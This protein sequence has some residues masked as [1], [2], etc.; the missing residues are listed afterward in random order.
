MET[1]FQTSFIP[2]KPLIPETGF[3]KRESISFFMLIGVV[4]FTL[5]ILS[6]G[7]V[8]VWNKILERKQIEYQNV[9]DANRKAFDAD[10]TEFKRFNSK[11]N[12][13]KELLD[14][15][16]SVSEVFKIVGQLT[17]ESVRFNDFTF[18]LPTNS[19]DGVTVTMKGTG[20]SFSTIAFQSD[21]LAKNKVIK[22]PIISDL[23]LD[24]NGL[25][26]FTFNGTIPVSQ[27]FYKNNFAKQDQNQ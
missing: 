19:K 7:G 21:E 5:S 4:L 20:N 22:D 12:L 23:N 9:L 15:H 16:L 1:K 17:A 10:I 13:S 18:S 14:N 25:V 3:G 11:I 6:A 27:I 26:S 24:Q 2:K 8:F